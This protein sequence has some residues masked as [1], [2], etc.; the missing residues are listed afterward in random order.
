MRDD[1]HGAVTL[2]Q[3]LF[4][5]A[6][7]VDVEVVGRFVEQENIRISKQRLRQ[8]HTQLPARSNF[9]H[10]AVVLFFIAVFFTHFRQ[11]ID[12]VALLLHF[13]QLFMPHDHRIQHSELFKGKLILTQF[14]NAL[15]G[16]EGNVTQRRLKVA[17]E[18]LHKGGFTTTVRAN[19]AYPE[20]RY[21]KPR[22]MP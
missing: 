8:K 18:D 21:D 13:P 1:D 20:K 14:T 16:I 22:I 10:R 12:A 7:G 5:P 11:S 9:T 17:A 15:V 3:H 2:V 6:N 4:Q 19:Q